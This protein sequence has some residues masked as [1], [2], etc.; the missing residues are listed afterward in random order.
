[1]I[2]IQVNTLHELESLV[3]VTDILQIEVLQLFLKI[4]FEFSRKNFFHIQSIFATLKKTYAIQK[5]YIHA[6]DHL[7]LNGA[8]RKTRILQWKSLKEMLHQTSYLGGDG[9]VAHLQYKSHLGKE[10]LVEEAET[11]FWDQP[12]TIPLVLE[13]VITPMTIGSDLSLMEKFLA[14]MLNCIGCEVCLDT[15]HLYQTGFRF[16][17]KEEALLLKAAFPLLFQHTTVLH[18]NDSKMPPNSHVDWHEHL[19]K[20]YIGLGA[21][22]AFISLFDHHQ[23]FIIE[24]PKKRFDD[25]IENTNIL[26]RLVMGNIKADSTE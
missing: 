6:P 11:V 5:I 8:N 22:G 20:G 4:P 16:R 3:K 12:P 19:G 17:D 18:I 24:T 26:R 2:G 25:F 21:L 7:L 23:S 14:G 15:A 1:M 10:E 13:N 9:V